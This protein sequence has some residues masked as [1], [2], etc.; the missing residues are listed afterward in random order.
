MKIYSSEHQIFQ[1]SI[2]KFSEEHILP[3]TKQ[4]EKSGFFPNEIFHRLG[5]QG[6]LGILID[7]ALGGVGGDYLLAGAWCEEFGRVPANGFTIGVNM[8]S[9]VITPTLA[10]LGSAA[11]KEKFLADALLGKAI[12]AY[13]FTEPGAG[14]D[15]TAIQMKAVRDG[16]YYILNG[17]KI[18]ITNGKRAN[19][20]LTLARTDAAKDY[21]GYTTFIVDTSLPGFSCTR[22]LDKL[23][24]HCS[25]TAEL[26]YIDVRVHKDF[27]LGE[28]GK[29]WHQAMDSLQWE[30]VMLSLTAL[31]G[32]RECIRETVEYVNNRKVFGKSLSSYENTKEVL[33]SLSTRLKIAEGLCHSTLLKLNKGER[34]RKES[35]L[36]KLITAELAIEIADRCLQLHGGY[37]Y[38]TEYP[39]EQWLRDLRLNTL[40]GGTSEIMARIAW[41]EMDV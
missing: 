4:W 12:G 8:H 25:D 16:D 34:A 39:P 40:G 27:V 10:R 28:V 32:A 11:A 36:C 13:A 18:F 20:V 24:W 31:G 23:G 15:L 2:R 9:L 38:T 37:G 17:S 7:D 1:N 29:G 26:N 6:Y 3:F 41:K 14:S 30:R 19:F 35:S 33:T 22:T 21:D 5:E